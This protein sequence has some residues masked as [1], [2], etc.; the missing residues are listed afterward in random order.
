MVALR[1]HDGKAA[2]S[3]VIQRTW[4]DTPGAAGHFVGSH[5]EFDM[6]FKKRG[7]GRDRRRDECSASRHAQRHPVDFRSTRRNGAVQ[8]PQS[9]S[10]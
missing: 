8:T 3:R 5:D 6:W 2:A 9:A 7:G 4:P 1:I 10:A